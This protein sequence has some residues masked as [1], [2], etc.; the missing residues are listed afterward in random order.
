MGFLEKGLLL[1]LC[2]AIA[3]LFWQPSI[4]LG[5][6][7]QSA[8]ILSVFNIDSVN[9]TNGS[10]KDLG[11]PGTLN[12]SDQTAYD[13]LTKVGSDT[14]STLIQAFIDAVANVMEYVKIFF[15]IVFSP[16]VIFTSPQ[17]ADAPAP[18][19]FVF[20]LPAILGLIVAIILFVRGV[21]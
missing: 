6:S 9:Q 3:I 4:I 15:R 7:E 1:Y 12:L 16:F 13:Q 5:E 10:I 21:S 11:L 18:V 2:L 20:A 8:H 14:T 19:L 17:M